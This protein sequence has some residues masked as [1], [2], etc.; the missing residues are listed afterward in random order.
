MKRITIIKGIVFAAALIP[1]AA[2]AYRFYAL[3]YGID[4]NA[5]TANPGDYITDQTGTWTISFLMISLGVTP[6]RRLT[7]WNELIRLRRM[8][9][10]FAFFYGTL[11]LLTWIVF[12]NYFDIDAM[13]QDVIKRPFITVGMGTWLI[14]FVLALTSNRFAVRKLKRRWQT[15]HRLVYVA[16]IGAVIHF[17]WLVKADTTEPRRWALVLALLLGIRLWWA[18]RTPRTAIKGGKTSAAT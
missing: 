2:L 14:L 15:L 12:I 1:A 7:K 11:H 6:L 13:V 5:L 9:G 4:L 10:L 16:G 18:S 8:L 3:Y 17:W